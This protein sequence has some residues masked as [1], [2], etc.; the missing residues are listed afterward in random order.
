MWHARYDGAAHSAEA[1]L[2]RRLAAG[3]TDEQEYERRVA[4]LRRLRA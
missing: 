4:T 3:E 1:D 2:A